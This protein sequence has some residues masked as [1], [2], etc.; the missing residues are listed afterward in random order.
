MEAEKGWETSYARTFSIAFITYVIAALVL[1][2]VG[3]ENY[4][5]AALVPT[6]GYL[7]STLSLPAVKRWWIK[8]ILAHEIQ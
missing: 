2:M 3:V 7:L 5:L 4:I 8:E 6:L 1:Y